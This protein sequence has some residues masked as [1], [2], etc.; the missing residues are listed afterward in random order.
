[1]FSIIVACDEKNGIGL[2]GTLPWNLKGDMKH[3][4]QTTKEKLRPDTKNVVIMG[5]K[6]FESIPKKFRPLP[7]RHNIVITRNPHYD[8]GE[9][10][11]V[12][13][14][15]EESLIESYKFA[16][17][18][19]VFV[20][21]GAEIYNEAF[22]HKKLT[23]VC[24]TRIEKDFNCDTFINLPNSRMVQWFSVNAEEGGIT[25]TIEKYKTKF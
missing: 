14:S 3:F 1:M 11:V 2:N 4:S 17:Y 23:E 15:L 8:A 5:R 10:V 24:L 16:D 13:H 20:I 9:G 6:T 7:G 25:Y 22:E 18:G 12:A 21:G 19:K